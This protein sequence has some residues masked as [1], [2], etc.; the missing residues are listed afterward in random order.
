M[1]GLLTVDAILLNGLLF[2]LPAK[3]GYDCMMHDHETITIATG[4]GI[5]QMSL[6]WILM[7]LMTIH[8]IWM[9][10]KMRKK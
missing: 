7:G 8:H 3:I 5:N 10:W 4:N 6:M 2:D 1:L 9:W